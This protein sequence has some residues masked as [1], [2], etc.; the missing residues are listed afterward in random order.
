MNIVAMINRYEIAAMINRKFI[1]FSAVQIYDIFI[2]HLHSSLSTGI[3]QTHNVTMKRPDGLI[4][5][6]GEHCT[7]ITEWVMGSNLVQA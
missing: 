1:S 4:A 3:L 7:G 2:N 5:Q 6:S